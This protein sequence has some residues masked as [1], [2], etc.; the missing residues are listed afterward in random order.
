[1][2]TSQ[3]NGVLLL[4]G[5]TASGKSDLAVA[6]AERFDAEII[7]A[8]SR[9]IYRN[10]SIGTAAP[11]AQ[12][13]ARVPHALVEF[14]DPPERYSV[15]K[16]VED[17]MET[18]ADIHARKKR[19]IVVGGTGFYI[20]ALCGD[21]D[22]GPEV[23][24]AARARIQHEV[25]LHDSEFLY[26]WLRLRNPK[27]AAELAPADTYRVTRALETMLA[28]I[29]GEARLP[30]RNLRS[31]QIP[32]AKV[33]VQSDREQLHERIERRIDAMLAAGFI[34]EAERVGPD[35]I[36]ATAVGYPHA[37]AYLAG[38]VTHKELREHMI[39]ATRRYAKR[40]TTWLRS[41]PALTI[42][43]PTSERAQLVGEIAIQ[44]LGWL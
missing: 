32:F 5:E 9:Q 41:E 38:Q 16:Y 30:H 15:A 12:Q 21:V 33:W 27:R 25:A 44:R 22:L 3:S 42:I 36:A 6:L 8:D 14:L 43:E 24:T 20:R 34:E 29:S 26:E 19:V 7:G 1:L 28:P 17:A 13:Q 39:R 37:L 31:E 11:T 35:A 2:S 23:D 10:M 4:T 40:Q 18:I